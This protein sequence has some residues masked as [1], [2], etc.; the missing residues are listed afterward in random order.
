MNKAYIILAHKQPELLYRLVEK[1]DDNLST[2]F[3]HIDKKKSLTDFNNL[4]D[5]GNKVEFIK[6]EASNWGEIGIVMAILNALKAVKE[7][8][9]K[10]E[11]IVL[12]S[13]QDYPIK[14]NDYINNFFNTSPYSV[15]IEYWTMP[16]FEV[17]KDRGG[18]FRI[19]KYFFGLKK[20]RRYMAKVINFIA[21]FLPFLK[22]KLPYNL[23]PYCG[24]MWWSIDY[25]ALNY[26]LQFLD[27]HPKY[28]KYHKYTF[29]PDE[30]FF[31]TILLNAKDER[32]LASITNN[33]MRYIRW[34]DGES[35]PEIL[36]KSQIKDIM[37]SDALFAR[38]VDSDKDEDILDL[39]DDYINKPN[40]NFNFNNSEI[41]AGKTNR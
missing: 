35:H 29:V 28:L 37:Q 39:I 14:S 17:W 8:D 16:N 2:F 25:Y 26:I 41:L 3:I 7:S 31:Q 40:R 4:L 30:F 34:K 15:F 24:W 36:R 11:H 33:N 6:R 10:I 27:D 32:L 18:M 9:K 12:L 1:L 5:F 13:G 38:K 23:K 19:T 20:R 22:R 21:I